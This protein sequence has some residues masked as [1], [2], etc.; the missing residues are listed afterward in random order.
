M[1]Q[2]K[3]FQPR[4]LTYFVRG[5]KKRKKEFRRAIDANIF[6]GD[7]ARTE[8][9][10]KYFAEDYK[11]FKDRLSRCLE[12]ITI[13]GHEPD[14][15]KIPEGYWELYNLFSEC[16]NIVICSYKNVRAG[17]WLAG[18]VLLRQA[19][20][21]I[22]VCIVIWQ[23]TSTNLPRFHNADLKASKCVGF[24]KKVMPA[25]VRIWGRLSNYHV[26]P[27]RHILGTSFIAEDEITGWGRVLIGGALLPEKSDDIE[28]AVINILFVTFYLQ[29]AIELI[30]WQAV[31]KPEFWQPLEE[32]GGLDLGTWNPTKENEDFL[33]SLGE[34]VLNI[35]NPFHGYEHRISP[36]DLEKYNKLIEAGAIQGL[37]DIEGLEK[38]MARE[39]EFH[40]VSYILANAYRY[41]GETEKAI[42]LYNQV[43][44]KA[45]NVYDSYYFLGELYSDM[46]EIDKAIEAYNK[47][48]E[49][50]PD[51]HTVLNR[52]G[53]LYDGKGDYDRAIECFRKAQEIEEQYHYAIINEGNSLMHKGDYVGAVSKYVEALEI[54]KDPSICHNAGLAYMQMDDM[55]NS[56]KQF[57][58][59]VVLDPGYFPSWMNLAG[60]SRFQGNPKKAYLCYIKCVHLRPDSLE[61]AIMLGQICIELSKFEKAAECAEHIRKIN[62]A[63]KKADEIIEVVEKNL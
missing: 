7:D 11:N 24:S 5:R 52:L 15:E 32:Y 14:R 44:T 3:V 55:D 37:Y 2:F 62:P 20:E 53:L 47:H 1:D 30:F 10:D 40:F 25:L 60:I 61:A 49:L 54:S 27:S 18:L 36:E 43:L 29:A 58:K 63:C 33:D 56:Y 45:E 38:V 35:E 41:V 34:R 26:H 46:G 23:D 16:I 48:V 22:A 59:A 12:I 19:I 50:H 28:Y 13:I 51:A 8:V 4:D 9:F 39:P 31:D 6:Q 42:K 57:R 17:Y 21:I